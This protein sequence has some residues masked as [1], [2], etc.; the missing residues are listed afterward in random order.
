[1]NQT[2]FRLHYVPRTFVNLDGRNGRL[3]L[4]IWQKLEPPNP[5]E[6]LIPYQVRVPSLVEWHGYQLWPS[7]IQP[8]ETIEVILVGER[9]DEIE[10]DSDWLA[11]LRLTSFIDG[12]LLAEAHFPLQELAHK[13]RVVQPLQLSVPANLSPG[14]YQVEVAFRPQDAAADV[15]LIENNDIQRVFN[16]WLLT[17]VVV[18]PQGEIGP[19]SVPIGANFGQQIWLRAADLPETA[20]PNTNI[21]LTFFWEAQRAPDFNYTIFIHLLNEAGELVAGRDTQPLDGRFPTR[22]WQPDEI[23]PDEHLLALP[24]DLPAGT[25]QLYVGLYRLKTGERLPVFDTADVEQPN[26]ALLL[27]TLTVTP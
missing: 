22:L 11:S 2:A 6:P 8:S 27:Q 17:S 21:S 12:Q 14:A 9:R 13:S 20:A 4:H 19:E 1:T 25:Y 3:P 26:G 18:P 24:P 15:L 23:I 16:R 7:R 10:P 5:E